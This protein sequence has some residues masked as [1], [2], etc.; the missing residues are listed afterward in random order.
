MFK[1]QKVLLR[2]TKREDMYRQWEF[3]ND[4]ELWFWDGGAPRPTKLEHILAI[5]DQ[6]ENQGDDSSVS[7]AIE[8]ENKYIGHC[9]L[10]DFDEVNRTCELSVEIGDKAYWGQGY[11]RDVVRLLLEYAFRHRNINRVWLK[12]HS[13]N[14]RAIRCY[15]ACGFIEEGRLRHHLWLKDQYVDRVIMGILRQE[16]GSLVEPEKQN[17]R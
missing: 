12:T 4:P 17:E 3:E 13:Q 6:K 14:E 10:S 5:F 11:G 8:V 15:L 9:G 1:G 7:F 2:S 16:A